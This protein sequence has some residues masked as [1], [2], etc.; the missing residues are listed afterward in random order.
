MTYL[1]PKATIPEAKLTKYLLIRQPK[2][3]KSAFLAQAGYNLDNWQKL[4]KDLREFLLNEATLNKKTSFGEIYEIKG[5]LVGSN[6][7][8][9]RVS[10]YWIIDSL[11]N[12]TRFITLLPD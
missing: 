9:L 6:S 4:E 5:V 2:D 1:D 12:E 7:V 11:T 10:T 8:S 3:D